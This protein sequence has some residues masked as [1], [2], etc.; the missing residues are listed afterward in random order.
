MPR[1]YKADGTKLVPPGPKERKPRGKSKLPIEV[2]EMAMQAL[3]KQKG[4]G[5][6]YLKEQAQKNP[7]AFMSLIGKMIP[8][9]VDVDLHILGPELISLMQERRAQVA[10]LRKEQEKVIEHEPT[11]PADEPAKRPRRKRRVP[12]SQA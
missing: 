8:R 12:K 3:R 4:G 1:G 7:V 10:Q 9:H 2:K 6:G 5:V 11:E